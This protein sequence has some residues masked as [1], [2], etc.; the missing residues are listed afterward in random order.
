[1]AEQAA[2]AAFRKE[3]IGFGRRQAEAEFYRRLAQIERERTRIHADENLSLRSV[4]D[5]EV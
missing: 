2:I 5:R 4:A 1:M 3:E